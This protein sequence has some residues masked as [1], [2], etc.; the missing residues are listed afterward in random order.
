MAEL[1]KLNTNEDK[2]G[3]LCVF[4][5]IFEDDIKRVFFV[6]DLKGNEDRGGEMIIPLENCSLLWGFTQISGKFALL[7]DIQSKKWLRN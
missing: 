2:S 4:E 5:K 1:I 3:K 6:Y 7:L